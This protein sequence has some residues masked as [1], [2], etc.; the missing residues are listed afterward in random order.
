[1]RRSALC[2]RLAAGA[3]AVAV[4]LVVA[5]GGRGGAEAPAPSTP[6]AP[7]TSPAPVPTPAPPQ[8][9]PVLIGDSLS[10]LAVPHLPPDWDIRAWPGLPLYRA[11][12]LLTSAAPL[13]A[14][15]VVI[16]MGSND[17]GHDRS[18]A[19][20]RAT[21]DRVD[22]ILAGHP[23]VL[24]TTVKVRGVGLADPASWVP[25]AERW[26][27]LLAEAADGTVLDWNAV[28]TAHPEWFTLDGLHPGLA[29]RVAYADLL[30]GGVEDRGRAEC[31]ACLH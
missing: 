10:V 2:T 17:V 31:N 29:G 15:C 9:P 13:R 26:N 1:M 5:L 18:E 16:A 14:R 23:C 22:R 27:R 8:G 6:S 21:I 24:W 28:A 3:T 11:I 7:W 20:M 4:L 12:P 25:A 19:R 30:R